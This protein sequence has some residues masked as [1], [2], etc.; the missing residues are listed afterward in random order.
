MKMSGYILPTFWQPC[1]QAHVKNNHPVDTCRIA[2]QCWVTRAENNT[3]IGW[4]FVWT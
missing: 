1:S 4:S 2:C 3:Y